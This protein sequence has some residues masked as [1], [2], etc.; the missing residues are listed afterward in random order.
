MLT[1]KC[2]LKCR[3]CANLMQYYSKPVNIEKS[4]LFEDLEDLLFLADEINEIRIIGGEPLVN[5]D[6]HEV[7]LKAA[8]SDKV[9]KVVVYT[10]GTI[11]PPDSKLKLLK[12][13]RFL[14][15]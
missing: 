8:S 2:S 14:F 4:E 15:S 7:C 9:N 6:F 13:K 10:N 11:C 1:E 3:D 12:N 5:K